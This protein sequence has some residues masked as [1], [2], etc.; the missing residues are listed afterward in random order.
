MSLRVVT[1]STCDVPRHLVEKFAITVVPVYINIGDRSYLDR[2]ELSRDEFY[3]S[4]PDYPDYPTT[5]APSSGTFTEVYERLAA[6]GATAILSIHL[7]AGLSA[8]C[9]AARLGA[10]ATNLVPV[11]VYDSKQI[12]MGSG[13][14]VLLAAEAAAKGYEMDEIV[15]LLDER[16]SRTRVFG[17]INDLSALRLSGRVSWAR[18]GLG[19]LLQLKPV[20]MIHGGEITVV[21]KVRTRKRAVAYMVK[22]VEEFGPF[23]RMAIIHVNAP[24]AAASL[25][26]QAVH[27]FPEEFPPEITN[28]TPAIGTHLG[29]GAIGF[30][31]ISS[32]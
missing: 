15:H 29:L 2:V 17:M 13:L 7:A 30:A 20:M 19:T 16:V 31:T 14:L 25:K 1:D 4:L 21:A 12:T 11:R 18:F 10:E 26:K 32:Q 3:N 28:I 23:E 6:E 22:M 27:L 5:A 24:Q 9:N 8:T